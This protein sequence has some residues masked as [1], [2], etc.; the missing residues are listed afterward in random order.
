[1]SDIENKNKN[2]DALAVAVRTIK[3]AIL[4]AQAKAA[5]DVNATQLSLYYGI[6]R[7]VSLNTRYDY[8]GNNA[9]NRLS[10]DLHRELPGLR[11]F[12]AEYIKKMRMFY[13]EWD[14]LSD[15]QP[16]DDDLKL[17]ESE[18]EKG[19]AIA[20][21]TLLQLS[22]M[23]NVR[24]LQPEDFFGISFSHHIEILHKTETLEERVFYIHQTNLHH[25]S[26]YVL[27]KYL[28]DDLFK[29]Q[30]KLPNNFLE[31][32]PDA[33]L[34]LKTISMFK[35]EYLLDFINV[36]EL[37]VRDREDIDER[38]VE[39]GIVRNIK[40]FI[41]AFGHDF[42]FIGNQ[43]RVE[44]MGHSHYIDLLFYN[45][46]LKC[47]VAVELKT[48]A[49]KNAYLGQLNGY[50]TVLD[51]FV[52]KP[53]EN[54]SIGILLCKSVDKNYAE[55]MVRSYDSPMGIATFKTADDMPEKLRKA[56]PD[57]EELKKLL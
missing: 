51:D 8:W 44:A 46:E 23:P 9:L 53:D 3:S 1:M 33:D 6:G 41:M 11:G 55:Y 29:H 45:R 32:I 15:G 26:K 21:N 7:Y 2:D 31:T 28:T 37:D 42:T 30:G 22:Q 56:L 19:M 13:E 39:N 27:R 40:N 20:E 48:G 12:S 49:F 18:A 43:Y 35:D 10:E 36:E 5:Q 4:R 25:W 52:R 47:L 16:Q 54:R 57:I 50:L 24:D 38:V 17:I 14:F 34:S